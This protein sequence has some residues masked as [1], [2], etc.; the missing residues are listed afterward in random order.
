MKNTGSKL[1]SLLLGSGMM[2][3]TTLPAHA[4]SK[5]DVN[6]AVTLP[7]TGQKSTVIAQAAPSPMQGAQKNEVVKKGYM[8]TSFNLDSNGNLNAKTKTWTDVRLKGFTGGVLIAFT[9]LNGAVIWSTEQQQYGVDGTW[10]GKSSRT[11][12]WPAKVPPETLGKIVGYAILQEPTPR[13]RALDWLRSSEGQATIKSIVK[14][15]SKN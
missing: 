14:I 1:F 11:E 9:D 7:P 12:N 3:A 8:E 2:L 15:F 4:L 10:V 13:G 5:S 6:H